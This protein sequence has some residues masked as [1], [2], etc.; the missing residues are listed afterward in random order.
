[1]VKHKACLF[2]SGSSLQTSRGFVVGPII[3]PTVAVAVAVAVALV[4]TTGLALCI[5]QTTVVV[6]CCAIVLI[7]APVPVL[8]RSTEA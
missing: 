7:N 6:G 8:N 1:M 4:G 3:L 5:Q 2:S